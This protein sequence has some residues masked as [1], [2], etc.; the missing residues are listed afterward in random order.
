MAKRIGGDVQDDRIKKKQKTSESKHSLRFEEHIKLK[1]SSLKKKTKGKKVSQDIIDFGTYEPLDMR[2]TEL[3]LYDYKATDDE[4]LPVFDLSLGLRGD[5][6]RLNE[7]NKIT[8]DELVRFVFDNA[9]LDALIDYNINDSDQLPKVFYSHNRGVFAYS[10]CLFLLLFSI[11]ARKRSAVLEFFVVKLWMIANKQVLLTD[12]FGTAR[13][14]NVENVV[15]MSDRH[16]QKMHQYFHFPLQLYHLFND[17][18]FAL[19][20]LSDFFLPLDFRISFS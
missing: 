19:V 13:R 20:L 12:Y 16:F 11:L 10:Y 2:R 1:Q 15:S 6:A 5:H 17:K 8:F 14:V 18:F 3:K 7:R 9:T 4:L